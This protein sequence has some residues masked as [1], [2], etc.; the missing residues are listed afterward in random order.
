MKAIV[1]LIH[2]VRF[3]TINNNVNWLLIVI[4][5]MQ[6]FNIQW[7]LFKLQKFGINK[8]TGVTFLEFI[9]FYSSIGDIS[10]TTNHCEIVSETFLTSI[11]IIVSSKSSSLRSWA[12][13]CMWPRVLASVSIECHTWFSWWKKK[14]TTLFTQMMPNRRMSKSFFCND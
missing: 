4:P 9:V 1:W 5:H 13:V 12:I 2:Q 3:V 10:K 7:C 14:H 6:C 8:V 11:F